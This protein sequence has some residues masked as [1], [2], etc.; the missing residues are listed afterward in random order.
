MRFLDG[1]PNG[2]RVTRILVVDDNPSVRRHLRGVLEE[3]EGWRVCDE[4]R[5]GQDAVDRYRQVRPDVILLD[6]QMPELNGLEAARII[7][8]LSP[9]IPILMLTLDLTKQL[10]EEAR[11]VGI[12]GACVKTD[13][14]SVVDAVEA[15]LREET[16]FVD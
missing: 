4:A 1:A 13:A 3:H 9:R 8:Q 16:Y 7:T 5:N 12:R 15:L 14:H 10:S 11:K 2:D 6:F